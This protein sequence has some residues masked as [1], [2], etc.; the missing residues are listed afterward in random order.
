MRSVLPV[1]VVVLLVAGPARA[2]QHAYPLPP[3]C[4]IA[5][6]NEDA[7]RA[8]AAF[9]FE[10]GRSQVDREAFG[11]A[12]SSFACSEAIIAHP[13]TLYNLARAAEWAGDLDTALTALREYLETAPDAENRDE[14]E[15]LVVGIA[16]RI[17]ERDNPPPPP[18]PP[19]PPNGHGVDGQRIAGWVAVAGAG[20]SAAAGVTLGGFAGAEQQKIDHAADGVPWSLIAG[21]EADRDDYLI[22]MGACFGVAAAAALTGVLLLVLDED[23]PVVDVAPTASPDGVGLVLVGRF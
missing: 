5:G 10:Q 13:S 21:H 17:D 20:A 9:W 6:E 14:V 2:E 7:R 8:L 22:G 15:E 19:P 12:E 4:R 1:L 16:A 18:P 23:E 3:E 11:E